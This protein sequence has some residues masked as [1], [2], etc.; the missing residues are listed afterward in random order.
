MS[1]YPVM[2]KWGAWHYVYQLNNNNNSW[3]NN[4]AWEK[5]TDTY[6]YTYKCT[7]TQQ[8]YK[9]MQGITTKQ[10]KNTYKYTCTYNT[11]AE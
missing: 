7:D 5:H 3:G 9:Y 2:G 4:L 11:Q 10:N 1:M 8:I 6:G